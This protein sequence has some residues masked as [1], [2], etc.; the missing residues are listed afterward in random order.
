MGQC[1]NCSA[2]NSFEEEV[3]KEE[4]KSSAKKAVRSFTELSGEVSSLKQGLSKTE[5]KTAT[6]ISEFDRLLSG[7]LIDGQT[8]LLA[9][10]PGIGKSTLMLQIAGSV[11]E[12]KKV[13]YVSGEESLGQISSRAKRLD[14]KNENV[15][16]LS[17]INLEKV[18]E[19]IKN[20]KPQIV[21]LDSIQ[22]IYHPEFNSSSGSVLQ[23]KE[24][25]AEAIKLCKSEGIILFI[26]G[27]ITKEGSLAGPK[28]LEHMVDTV[29]YFDT[30]KDSVLKVLRAYKNRFGSTDE[31]GL[32][33]MNEK[34]LQSVQDAGIYS[35]QSSRKKPLAGRAFS[36]FLEGT[37]P[38]VAEIQ[39]LV[40]QTVYPFP[41]RV[42]SGLDLNR[43]Q[44]LLAAMEKHLGISFADKDVFIS[45]AGG[46]KTK[47]P[48]LDLAIC[49][50]VMSSYR[51]IEISHKDV[52]FAEVGILGQLSGVNM[53]EERI[54]SAKR[55]GFERVFCADALSD[56]KISGIMVEK[57]ENLYQL[58]SKLKQK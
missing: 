40:S 28:I 27:H 56:L 19:K 54:K 41:K 13:L 26:L 16:V 50:S 11:D 31:V 24:S 35:L 6:K 8:I 46:I 47:D 23:I 12:D 17:E 7:G 33:K 52:F 55:L 36:L 4:S 48:S 38:L 37:R 43:C 53:T 39:A 21:V 58:S 22:T 20:I 10:A 32:F 57:L 25:A 14:I 34:G 1:P 29:L 9:G 3:I 51:D 2:W 18:V 45:I 49:A 44:I 5:E 30:E 42:A 15:L